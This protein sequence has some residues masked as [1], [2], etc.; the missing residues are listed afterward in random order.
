MFIHQQYGVEMTIKNNY[1]YTGASRQASFKSRQKENGLKLVRVWVYLDDE[2]KVKDY[3]Q[4][5]V[6]EREK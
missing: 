4:N 6:A 1:D 5:L 2:Q 3:A